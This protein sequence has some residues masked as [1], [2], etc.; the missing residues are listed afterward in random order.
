MTEK[1]NDEVTKLKETIGSLQGNFN[2][3][4]AS[5]ISHMK[6]TNQSIEDLALFCGKIGAKTWS[7][8]VPLEQAANQIANMMSTFGAKV[9]SKDI[10]TDEGKIIIKDWPTNELL[11]LAEVTLEDF[12]KFYEVWKPIVEKQ[13]LQFS[14]ERD[15]DS[16]KISLKK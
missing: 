9:E 4:L 7:E 5:T 2:L 14:F 6:K 3:L 15:K 1:K 16:M 11:K 8:D 13:N 10:K 12:E